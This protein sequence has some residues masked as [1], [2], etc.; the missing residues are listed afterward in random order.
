M[1]NTQ[2]FQK[3]SSRKYV[4]LLKSGS[5]IESWQ[6]IRPSLTTARRWARKAP[7]LSAVWNR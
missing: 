5:T 1:G 6:A 3:R 7:R 2:L 4:G